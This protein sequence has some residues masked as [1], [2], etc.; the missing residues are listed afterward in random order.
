MKYGRIPGLEKPV[1]RIG[2]GTVMLNDANAD[3]M[4]PLLDAVYESGIN[5]FDS[6]H[7]YGGGGSDRAFGKWVRARGVQ[8]RIVLMDKCC[9]HNADRRRVTPF[10]ITCDLHD[11]L[12]RLKFE[13]VDVFAFHRDDETQPVGPLVERMNQHIREGKIRA[14]GASNWSHERIRQAND[15]AAANVLVPMA[16]GSPHYSL[17][18]CIADPWGGGVTITGKAGQAARDWYQANQMALLPWSALCGG[19]FTGRFRRSNLDTFAEG[20]DKRT[21][22][23]YCC[24][25]NFRRLDR[26]A[27]LAAE[28]GATV[29]QVA[30]AYAIAG[31]LN[32]FAL[33]AAWKPAE[34]VENARA[35]ELELTP[36]ECA[37]LNLESDER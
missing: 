23:C 12:A 11:C 19:F 36:A 18:E 9:H 28:K 16:I 2:Q 7:V 10:D 13:P 3:P 1:S 5:L 6:A 31:P 8:D 37:W 25:D 14:Y 29:A 21:V 17:A 24:E 32:V 22:R 34:A 26:A 20:A 27:E 35:A 33:M 30:L 15:Y 4:L